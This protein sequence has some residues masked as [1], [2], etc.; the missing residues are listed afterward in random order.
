MPWASLGTNAAFSS[1]SYY[2]ITFQGKGIQISFHTHFSPERQNL[3][4][5][6][7]Y[8]LFSDIIPPLT[9]T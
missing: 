6:K 3:T 7:L 9:Q 4:R 1:L 8:F 5:E 2:T